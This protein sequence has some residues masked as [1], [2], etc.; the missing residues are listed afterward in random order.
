LLKAKKIKKRKERKE[1]PASCRIAKK[2]QR[3]YPFP[4]KD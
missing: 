3:Y 1:E 4:N 2:I